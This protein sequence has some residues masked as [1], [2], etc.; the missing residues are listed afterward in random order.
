MN[1]LKLDLINSLLNKLKK[2]VAGEDRRNINKGDFRLYLDQSNYIHIY[3]KNNEL[4]KG[5]GLYVG[6][7]SEGKWYR[8]CD[9]NVRIERPSADEI[10]IS[11][12]HYQLPVMQL[13]NL[14]LNAQGL[15]TWDIAMQIKEPLR[16][17]RFN[18]DIFLSKIYKKW[19]S[20]PLDGEFPSEFGPQWQI[21]NSHKEK[22][23]L[24]GVASYLEDI[25]S[26]V[27]KN[28]SNST[29]LIGNTELENSSRVLE[30]C[31]V[32]EKELQKPGSYPYLKADI[33]FYPDK[34]PL[35]ETIKKIKAERQRKEE[36]DRLRVITI[37]DKL[38]DEST[39]VFIFAESEYLHDRI[40]SRKGDFQKNIAKIKTFGRSRA[41]IRLGI[42]KY[43]FFKL[44]NIAQ[45]CCSLINQ[46]LDLRSHQ[47]NIF[48]VHK[49][50][51]NFID[52][53]NELNVCLSATNIELFILDKDLVNLL[54][55]V[56]SQADSYNEKNLLRLL[57]VITEHAFIGPQTIVL[58]TFHRCNTNCIHCWIHSPQVR[59][60]SRASNIKM[61]L[62][63]F[64][65][66]I[67]D[68][69]ELLTDE[70]IIQGDGEPLMDQRLIE[71]MRYARNKGLKVLFF[72]NGILLDNIKAKE[73]IDLE[74]EEIF[75]SLPAGTDKT[76][77]MINSMRTAE[78]F[79]T[80]VKNLKS[81]IE[82]RN[83]L[84][85]HKPKLQISH[86][87][88]N[89]N[90]HELK[91]MAKIDAYI[92]ADKA[93]FYLARLDKNNK[94]LKLSAS[95]IKELKNNLNKAIPY[96]KRSKIELQDNINFQLDNYDPESGNWSG[97][98]LLET[99]CPVGWFFCL[100]LAKG[101]ISMCCHLRIV[102]Y[103]KSK[104]FRDIWNSSDYD[105]F[106]AQ[107]KH[108]IKN[109]DAVLR[110]NTKLWDDF[111]NHCDTHQVILGINNSLKE[112]KLD[113]FIDKYKK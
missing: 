63:L 23:E 86:V 3:Y 108:L 84:G 70:I 41:K 106:R 91:E 80:I 32:E 64:K 53:V 45:F 34:A 59:N 26:V 56:S 15:L 85:R 101:E 93:R 105:K 51:D 11:F 57:G 110:N 79:N 49:L 25:P 83:K 111:C 88:H 13:W 97:G 92:G 5:P 20:L 9:S 50:Y 47:L 62:G 36:E 43:N 40:I 98:K 55:S 22:S 90:Y 1:L 30:M 33:Q 61:D 16:I 78:T 72:T 31:F 21:V 65:S 69:S 27:L 102:D 7:L 29:V 44:S 58:D 104:H 87:I 103:L 109:K 75:C 24:V 19:F 67:D 60:S 73:F 42:S 94:A 100:I 48:P 37:D 66:I 52:Y 113:K 71:M 17:D 68:A 35:E 39:S 81:M 107:A 18:A 10:A 74:I 4:T 112:F 77:A 8:L 12:T 82:L 46:H 76:Y 6:I 14:K 89:L 95:N 28:K 54:S 96:F 2:I 99:G 38:K